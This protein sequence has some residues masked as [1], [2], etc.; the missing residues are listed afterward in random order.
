MSLDEFFGEPVEFNPDWKNFNIDEILKEF[1]CRH[2][3]GEIKSDGYRTRCLYSSLGNRQPIVGDILYT[4]NGKKV[5]ILE[6]DN[7]NYIFEYI[8]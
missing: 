3:Y 8:E 6:F 1:I 7:D 2:L 5:Q 4:E